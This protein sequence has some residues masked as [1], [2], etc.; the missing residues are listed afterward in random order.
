M[1]LHRAWEFVGLKNPSSARVGS[2]RPLDSSPQA[3]STCFAWWGLVKGGGDGATLDQ[4]P[5][6]PSAITPTLGARKVDPWLP[7]QRPKSSG[8]RRRGRSR[9]SF[10]S[11]LHA[12][13]LTKERLFSLALGGAA[14]GFI[15]KSFG[16][17]LPTLPIVG[18]A[19]TITIGA[20]MFA[21]GRGGGIVADIARAGAV[22][23]GYQIGSTGKISGDMDGPVVPQISGIAAQV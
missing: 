16:P 23:S 19:G 1:F 18:R 10:A 21:K 14:Y 11:L 17:Q 5:G 20:Y 12:P 22:I 4:W 13:G 8:T 2:L 7:R 9:R 3:K 15:E 6:G